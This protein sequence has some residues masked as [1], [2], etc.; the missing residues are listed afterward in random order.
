MACVLLAKPME[1]DTRGCWLAWLGHLGRWSLLDVYFALLLMMI[2]WQQ[3]IYVTLGPFV[4][5]D[6]SIACY[7][8]IGIYI[9]HFAILMSMAAV[10][11]CQ[12]QSATANMPPPPPLPEPRPPRRSLLHSAGVRGYVALALAATCLTLQLCAVILPAFTIDCRHRS[13]AAR[14][15]TPA[16]GSSLRSVPSSHVLRTSCPPRTLLSLTSHTPRA[17]AR[18]R[19]RAGRQSRSSPSSTR[20]ALPSMRRRRSSPP[21]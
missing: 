17:R 18:V 8:E 15:T 2:V 10:T 13:G 20:S 9:F 6:Q 3:G 19:R 4:T 1:R 7:P 11:I 21:S 5:I 14:R 16:H 12:E